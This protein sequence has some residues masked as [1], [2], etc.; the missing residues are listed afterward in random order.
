[1]KFAKIEND[2][3]VNIVVAT[4]EF[5]QANGLTE[6]NDNVGIGWVIENGQ[7][8]EPVIVETLDEK[9]ARA[10]QML[11]DYGQSIL[12]QGYT[13]NFGTIEEPNFQVLQLR[14]PTAQNDDE[15]NWSSAL[16]AYT[17]AVVAGQGEV[18]GATIR[19]ESN[20]EIVLSFAD[21]MGL[22]MSMFAWAAN[23]YKTT[24]QKKDAINA[25][26]TE[27]ELD[28]LIADIPNGW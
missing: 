21:G 10:L 4:D 25:A 18:M 11:A 20:A 8:V 12:R 15:K 26:S 17:A 14:A 23:N 6:V 27:A 24:W 22:L 3:V 13:H 19:V 9:R 1:M 2:V 5:A 16:G 28:A 7:P